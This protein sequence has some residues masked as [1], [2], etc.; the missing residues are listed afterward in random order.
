MCNII[1][2]YITYDHYICLNNHINYIKICCRGRQENFL[3]FRLFHRQ[4][5]ILYPRRRRQENQQQSTFIK[6]VI[7]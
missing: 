6:K 2:T 5:I 1:T 3:S 7:L 4:M